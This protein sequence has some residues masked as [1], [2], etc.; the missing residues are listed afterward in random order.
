[1]CF[2]SHYNSMDHYSYRGTKIVITKLASLNSHKSRTCWIRIA[3]AYNLL[4]F[5]FFMYI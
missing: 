3:E 1:M 4:I 5:V 2:V